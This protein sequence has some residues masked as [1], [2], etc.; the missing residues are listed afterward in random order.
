MYCNGRIEAGRIVFVSRQIKL[1]VNEWCPNHVAAITIE[2]IK[3]K[4]CFFY[5]EYITIGVFNEFVDV[6]DVFTAAINDQGN[7]TPL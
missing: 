7:S 2:Y 6:F 5:V 3:R 1:I 4:Q